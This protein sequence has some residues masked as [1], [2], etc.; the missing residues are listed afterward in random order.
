M[1]ID[2]IHNIDNN[3]FTRRDTGTQLLELSKNAF[4][5]FELILFYNQDSFDQRL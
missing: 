3:P 1:K 4:S 5:S 2:F